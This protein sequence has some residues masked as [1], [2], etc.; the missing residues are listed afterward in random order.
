MPQEPGAAST[1][2][3]P[4]PDGPGP[5]AGLASALSQVGDRWSLLIVASLLDGP[6]RFKDLGRAVEGIA[7]NILADRLRRLARAGVVV[8]EAYSRR[9]L[10]LEYR[11]TEEGQELAGFL[12]LL[13]GWG[14]PRESPAGLHHATCGTSVEAR[15]YCPTCARL[16]SEDE[17]SDLVHL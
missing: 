10:R 11:L 15:W 8:S 3:D 7:P 9:P 14:G 6:L 13:A 12:R 16:V 17:G 2:S 1:P 4:T 5:D